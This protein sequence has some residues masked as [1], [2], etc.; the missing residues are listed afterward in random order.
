LLRVRHTPVLP[1]AGTALKGSLGLV[2]CAAALGALGCTSATRRTLPK[3]P[4][5]TR[6]AH[7]TPPAELSPAA[8]STI[9]VTLEQLRVSSHDIRFGFGD[10]SELVVFVDVTNLG[11]APYSL[12]AAAATC[13]MELAPDRPAETLSLTPISG[14]EGDASRGRPDDRK[15][16]PITIAPGETRRYWIAFRGYRYPRSDVPRKITV[17]FP[18]DGNGKPVRLVLAD[19]A[20]AQ[21]WEVQADRG[22]AGYGI[23]YASLFASGMQ[24][25][26]MSGVLTI[27]SRA[28]PVFFDVG[29]LTGLFIANAGRLASGTSTFN[30]VGARVHLAVPFAS[31]GTWQAPWRLALYAGAGGHGLLGG[32]R[33]EASP[34]G[35]NTYAVFAVEGGIELDVGAQ[36]PAA[37]PYPISFTGRPLPRVSL[38]VG[39]THWFAQSVPGDDVTANSGG[40][41]TAIRVSFF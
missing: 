9:R 25:Q 3:L 20:R 14:G 2:A 38:R 13:W 10:D 8:G 11:S 36:A 24:G 19:P 35:P 37:L 5:A 17:S 16:G 41:S 21:R 6:V 29:I 4:V 15:L 31:W 34:Q 22:V 7:P 26:A 18:P 27:V 1:R 40:Y 30:I 28:G 39:Y 23:K 33:E 32:R 12:D